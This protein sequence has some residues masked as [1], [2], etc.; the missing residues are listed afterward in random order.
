VM[1]RHRQGGDVALVVSD[2]LERLLETAHQ[3]HSPRNA[4]R[5][6][7]DLERACSGMLPVLRLK[8]WTAGSRHGSSAARCLSSSIT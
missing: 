3:L 7:S 8:I 2:A 5:L 1:M 6:L 4:A